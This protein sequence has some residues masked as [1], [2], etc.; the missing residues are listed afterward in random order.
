[1]NVKVD[2]VVRNVKWMGMRGT[3]VE[4]YDNGWTK[5]RWSNGVVNYAHTNDLEIVEV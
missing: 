4:T 1:M 5:V 3:V 2:D